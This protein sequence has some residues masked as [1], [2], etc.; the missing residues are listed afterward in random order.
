[1]KIDFDAFAAFH[2]LVVV[3]YCFD[4]AAE[5]VAVGCFCCLLLLGHALRRLHFVPSF[6][7]AFLC[8]SYCSMNSIMDFYGFVPLLIIVRPIV[9][10]HTAVTLVILALS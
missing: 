1:V 9:K 5:V 2:Y 7:L 3:D 4:A 6:Y 8:N 10:G